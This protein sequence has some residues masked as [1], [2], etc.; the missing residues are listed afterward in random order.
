MAS[1]SDHEESSLSFAAKAQKATR[2]SYAGEE[3][4]CMIV[5]YKVKSG[6]SA[7]A[8]NTCDILNNA[9]HIM[10]CGVGPLS[11]YLG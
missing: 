10:I 6:H 9:Y 7:T 4:L 8:A 5:F 11:T 1:T 2:K 3:K